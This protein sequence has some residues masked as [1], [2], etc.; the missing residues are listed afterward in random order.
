MGLLPQNGYDCQAAEDHKGF[1]LCFIGLAYFKPGYF[2]L[3]CLASTGPF[4]YQNL[5]KACSIKANPVKTGDAKL[6]VYRHS[7]GHDRRAAE[8]QQMLANLS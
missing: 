4:R 6:R 3:G 5:S 2:F 1:H 8:N 7:I